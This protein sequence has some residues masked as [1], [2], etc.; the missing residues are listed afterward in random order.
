MAGTPTGQI[1]SSHLRLPGPAWR[2]VRVA[3]KLIRAYF[4]RVYTPLYDFS[5][6]QFPS[7]HRLHAECLEK[8]QASGDDRVL[9]LGVGTGNEVTRLLGTSSS[10][11]IVGADYARSALLRARKKAVVMGEE[12]TAT[13]MDARHLAFA[14]ESFD[15]VLCIHVMD[16]VAGREQ[17]T[18]EILRV[19]RDGGR[20]VITYPSGKEGLALGLALLR[21]L[22]RH[23]GDTATSSVRAFFKLLPRLLAGAAYLPLLMR[24]GKVTYSRQD[25]TAMMANFPTGPVTVDE[26]TGYRDFIVSGRRTV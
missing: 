13:V 16:F 11:R 26:D 20:F 24:S 10:V 17:V 15:R 25:L 3:G 5:T 1:S 4:D 12:I 2:R 22:A 7:Y 23:G 6:G 9:C 21:D 19:L 14:P 8:L 18:S